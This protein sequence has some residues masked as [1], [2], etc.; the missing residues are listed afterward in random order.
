MAYYKYPAAIQ[1]F[2]CRNAVCFEY[3]ELYHDEYT[4]RVTYAAVSSLK[5]R[6]NFAR[7]CISP[8][9]GCVHGFDT[10]IFLLILSTLTVYLRQQTAGVQSHFAARVSGQGCQQFSTY[11]W[12]L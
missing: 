11:C 2:T 6:T 10:C 3:S 12:F 7:V 9:R 5:I 8:A 1:T 4:A